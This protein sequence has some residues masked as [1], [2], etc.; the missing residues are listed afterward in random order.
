M[1]F[2]LQFKYIS[3]R[4]LRDVL[5][6]WPSLS[7]LNIILRIVSHGKTKQRDADKKQ[8]TLHDTHRLAASKLNFF[9]NAQHSDVM[10]FLA[11]FLTL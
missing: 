3:M 11:H 2:S 5:S 7:S 1:V 9:L 8:V 10:T 6:K 4:A